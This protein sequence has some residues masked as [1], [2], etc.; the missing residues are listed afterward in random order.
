MYILG[1]VDENRWKK[2]KISGKC[3]QWII[4]CANV[5]QFVFFAEGNYWYERQAAMSKRRKG[6]EKHRHTHAS[7]INDTTWQL[8]SE[9]CFT[10]K[11][12]NVSICTT[13]FTFSSGANHSP[14]SRKNF[15]DKFQIQSNLIWYFRVSIVFFFHSNLF[16]LDFY[17]RCNFYFFFRWF[18][19]FVRWIF[20]M[21]FN[22]YSLHF[23]VNAFQFKINA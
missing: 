18:P 8:K 6:V 10:Y 7:G 14:G 19:I 13:I 17:H 20:S 9:K 2:E 23:S 4:S 1:T 16:F 11:M 3:S 12:I 5:I 15:V 21:S 22:F